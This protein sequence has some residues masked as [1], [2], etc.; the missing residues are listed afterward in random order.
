MTALDTLVEH[1]RLAR[2]FPEAVATR[3]ELDLIDEICTA[4]VA[5]HSPL[6]EISGR[7]ALKAQIESVR[8]AFEDFSAT[9]EDSVAEDD[10][11]AM[12]VTLRGRH[13]GEFMGVE[14]T[15]K[16]VEVDNMVFTRFE[17]DRIAERWVQPD[18]LGMM[19]QVGAVDL[20]EA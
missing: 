14:A 15:G 3:G 6:G 11:V 9:V 19:Q 10:T 5:D 12:R 20:P 18:L 4:D 17:D 8:N 16:D 1:K 2:Q 13:V 7:D